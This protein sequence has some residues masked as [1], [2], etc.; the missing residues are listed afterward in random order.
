[1]SVT[2]VARTLRDG[3]L[4]IKDGDSP[5]NSCTVVCDNGDVRWTENNDWK[6]VKCRG[7]LDHV[8][9]G[10]EM[11]VELSCTLKWMQLLGYTDDS[12]NAIQPYEMINNLDNAFTSVASGHYALKWEFTVSDPSTGAPNSEKITFNKVRKERLECAEGDEF[13]TLAFTGKDNEPLPT[14]ARL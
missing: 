10:D 6:E 4:V 5:V 9:P 3:A 12:S 2:L 1:V 7:Q 14:V 13:N 11:E 8:R